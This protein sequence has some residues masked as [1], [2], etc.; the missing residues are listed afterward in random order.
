MC[1]QITF[2]AEQDDFRFV[3]ICEHNI[4]HMAWD[5]FTVYLQ[6]DELMSL[7]S[8]L[9]RAIAGIGELVSSSEALFSDNE[10]GVFLLQLHELAIRLRPDDFSLLSYMVSEAAQQLD[11]DIP[12]TENLDITVIELLHPAPLQHDLRYSLN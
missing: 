2:L 12:R 8:S 3:A 6:P 1:D 9:D 11:E 10:N 4:V 7:D 5:R